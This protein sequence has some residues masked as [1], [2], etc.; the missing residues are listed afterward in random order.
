MK[1]G[2]GGGHRKFSR[3]GLRIFHAPYLKKIDFWPKQGGGGKAH[4]ISPWISLLRDLG[5]SEEA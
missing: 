5:G 3:G 1:G 4:I 2:G